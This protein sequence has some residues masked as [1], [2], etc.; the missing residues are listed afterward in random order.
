MPPDDELANLGDPDLEIAG[1]RLWV[2]GRQFPDSTD[3][4]D[5]NWLRVTAYA[6]SPGSRVRTHGSILHLSEVVQLK[7]GCER[8]YETLEGRAGLDCMEPDLDVEFTARGGGHIGVKVSINP[9]HLS[10]SHEFLDEIDQTYLPGIIAACRRILE[11]LPI[12][13]P[14]RAPA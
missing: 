8:L 11:R 14:E 4:W 10:E 13:E 12:R 6:T 3:Y 2:H 1:L 9:D 5:G 7:H